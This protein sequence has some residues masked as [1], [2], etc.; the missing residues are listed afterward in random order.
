MSFSDDGLELL[1][2]ESK[3]RVKNINLLSFSVRDDI[4]SMYKKGTEIA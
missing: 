1:C 4:D 3:R 2:N